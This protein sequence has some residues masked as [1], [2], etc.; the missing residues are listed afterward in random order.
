MTKELT[1][2]SVVAITGAGQ[3]IGRGLALTFAQNGARAVV[4]GVAPR[5]APSTSNDVNRNFGK[6]MM[7]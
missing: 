1:A 7:Y 3:G 2:G 4:V 5:D 6:R